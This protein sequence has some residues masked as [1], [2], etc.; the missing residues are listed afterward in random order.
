MMNTELT[1]RFFT[2]YRGIKFPPKLLGELEIGDMRK[3]SAF[4]ATISTSQGNCYVGEK[5]A[6]GEVE[7]RH[8]YRHHPN[9]Q[10]AR[11]EIADGSGVPK[12]IDSP[13]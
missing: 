3:R 13:A 7:L 4:P 10:L 2:S 9:G 11:A 5:T 6:Y 1:T 12:I 8:D